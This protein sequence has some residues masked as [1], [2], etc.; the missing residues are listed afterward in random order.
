MRQGGSTVGRRAR[1]EGSKG[2]GAPCARRLPTPA[3]SDTRP[4]STAAALRAGPSSSSLLRSAAP[5][6]RGTATQLPA[7][8][9]RASS[10]HLI[11]ATPASRRSSCSELPSSPPG[12]KLQLPGDAAAVKHAV[13]ALETYVAASQ[14]QQQMRASS[15]SSLLP[16]WDELSAV[17]VGLADTSRPS[18]AG[19]ASASQRAI[20]VSGALR[21]D[22]SGFPLGL[23][24]DGEL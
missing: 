12:A 10:S 2:G 3:R 23:L 20:R 24:G 7:A 22:A 8:P 9:Q 4:S 19:R 5:S 17:G 16:A 13:S 18:T 15:S 14:A 1:S 6:A 11:L 21:I